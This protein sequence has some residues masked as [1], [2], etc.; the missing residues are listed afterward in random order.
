[1]KFY[2]V[3]LIFLFSAISYSAEAQIG[4]LRDKVRSAI[5]GDTDEVGRGL[6]EALEKGVDRGTDLLAVKDGYYKSA[7]KILLPE[8]AQTVVNRLKSVPGFG[9]LEADLIERLNRAA[10]DAASKAKPIFRKA[11]TSMTIADAMNILMGERNA[12]T[13][14]LHRVTYD[15]LYKEFIPVIRQSLDAVNANELWESAVTAY[16]RIPMV[17][18]VNPRLDDHVTRKGLD[19]L[20]GM[21]EKE[22]LEIRTN[23]AARTSELLKKVFA[24]QDKK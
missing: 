24:Q 16:N 3:V 14:Y 5:T 17:Q 22:E 10:E 7:Y 9:N 12:A 18:R 8:E 19:G 21:V 1:M 15:D 4:N 20:F 6:K 2:H 11:I 23:T 13:L